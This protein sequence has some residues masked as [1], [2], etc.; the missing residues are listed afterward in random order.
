MHW[1]VVPQH[2]A[3]PAHITGEMARDNQQDDTFP[4]DAAVIAAPDYGKA[5]RQALR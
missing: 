5:C 4:S 3:N 2:T 1:K